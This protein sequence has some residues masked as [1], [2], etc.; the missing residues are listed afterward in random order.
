VLS[1]L[2]GPGRA[3]A[4]ISLLIGLVLLVASLIAALRGTLSP[5]LLSDGTAGEVANYSS[6]RFTH[7]PE[8]W[9]VHVRAIHGSL[10]SI[11]S[12]TR[13]IDTAVKFVRKAEYFFFAGL[14]TVGA[15]FASLIVV[16]SF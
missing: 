2:Q 13:Q 1:S 9:R 11:E 10:R 8:L 16:I 4:G 5:R 6:E 12:M 15:A 7:E 14:F 3:C